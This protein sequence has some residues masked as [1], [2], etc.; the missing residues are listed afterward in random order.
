[1]AKISS[2]FL[3]L[4]L[5]AGI[6]S[7][8]SQIISYPAAQ[9]PNKKNAE[10]F[11][12]SLPK[13]VVK[14]DVYVTKTEKFKGRYSDFATKLLSI[15]DP[16][17]KDAVSYDISRVV[18][19]T[20][21]EPDTSQVYFAEL[22][23]KNTDNRQIMLNLSG[24]GFISDFTTH[25]ID[26]KATARNSHHTQPFIDLLRPALIEK[27]DTIIRKVSI[28]TSVFEQKIP[29]RNISEKS[30]EQQAREIA[31]EIYKIEDS[32]YK[33]IT[34]YQEVNY[35]SESIEFMLRQLNA[36]EENYLAHF[37]G[38]VITTES[39][40][41][42]YYTPDGAIDNA[43]NTIFRFSTTSGITTRDNPVGDPVSISIKRINTL[44]NARSLESNSTANRKKP[45]GIWYR[46][47]ESA[48]ITVNLGQRTLASE[49]FRISQL[50]ILTCLPPSNISHVGFD[51]DGA[52]KTLITD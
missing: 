15:T 7:L 10:G 23:P 1:M 32:K 51:H 14:I 50:G 44:G 16:I 21:T 40:Y 46:I 2:F 45:G 33:L 20:L 22:S 47:P 29:R 30:L 5:F 13:H 31:G 27:V 8:Q 11:L 34:G 36:L 18:V 38:S 12:Y 52:L 3:C 48:S 42:Y 17:L 6:N 37:K 41:T 35:S 49:K 4:A 39:V 26:K 24:D 28:D 19:S 43:T 25:Y 9:I